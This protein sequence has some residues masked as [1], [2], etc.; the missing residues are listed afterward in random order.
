M[1]ARA[2][3]RIDV[4]FSLFVPGNND[5]ASCRVSTRTAVPTPHQNGRQIALN[6]A[7]VLIKKYMDRTCRDR[8]SSFTVRLILPR[9]SAIVKSIGVAYTSHVKRCGTSKRRKIQLIYIF[10]VV[11]SLSEKHEGYYL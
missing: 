1:H 7:W 5:F 11:I 10:D 9:A 2:I 6:R 8:T 4:R 3:L